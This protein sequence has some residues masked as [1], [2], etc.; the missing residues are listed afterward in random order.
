MALLSIM[1]HASYKYIPSLRTST[2]HASPH[3]GPLAA[4]DTQALIASRRRKLLALQKSKWPTRQEALRARFILAIAAEYVTE[5]TPKQAFPDEPTD[6]SEEVL[7]EASATKEPFK[8]GRLDV[9]QYRQIIQ[10]VPP[11]CQPFFSMATFLRLPK[12]DKGRI[13]AKDLDYTFIQTQ[14][15]LQ[16]RHELAEKDTSGQGFL[17]ES[18]N[19]RFD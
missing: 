17:Q 15:L 14:T 6:N 10:D 5:A 19:G 3:L 8:E 7:P 18:V 1:Q 13:R 11:R 16:V 12:D 2:L 9:Y 4:D